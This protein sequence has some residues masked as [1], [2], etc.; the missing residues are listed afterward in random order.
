M[1]RVVYWAVF[2]LFLVLV[3]GCSTSVMSRFE[4]RVVCTVAKDEASV[5]SKWGLFGIASQVS[6][7]DRK[8]I[9][10]T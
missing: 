4:N 10:E 3:A 1:P 5:I 8:K 2:V 7:K 9:C 6:E